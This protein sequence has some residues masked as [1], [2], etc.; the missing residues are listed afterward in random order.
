M[1]FE[2]TL[3]IRAPRE[4]VWRFLTDPEKVS[5]CAPG[6]ESIE[7]IAPGERFRAVASVGFGALKATFANEVEW[8][9]LEPPSRARMKVHG[10][11][12]GSAVDATSEMLLSDGP[13]GATGLRWAAEVSVVGTIASIAAR[14]MGAW[15]SA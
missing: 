13:E 14:L 8:L 5:R 12:P 15:H 2:G 3:T 1:R 6:L 9:D 7:V 4:R 11:A 10:T